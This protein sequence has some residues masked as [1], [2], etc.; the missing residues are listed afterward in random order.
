MLRCTFAC[1]G[2]MAKN[3]HESG[4]LA[5]SAR[6]TS[7]SRAQAP[8]PSPPRS[9]GSST[10]GWVRETTRRN[11][12]YCVAVRCRE[13]V[14]RTE[15]CVSTGT[16][17]METNSSDVISRVNEVGLGV[18]PQ[19]KA[20]HTDQKKCCLHL[21]CTVKFHLRTCMRIHLCVYMYGILMCMYVYVYIDV[22]VINIYIDMYT[23]IHF[24]LCL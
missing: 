24:T 3:E 5:A 17:S 16:S 19:R 13:C 10:S 7:L 11:V 14:C 12:L 18:R 1:F 21:F 4:I 22:H 6:C 23:Q 8:S 9:Y 15:Q 2:V 20:G